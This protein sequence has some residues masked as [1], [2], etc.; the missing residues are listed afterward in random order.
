MGLEYTYL[1]SVGKAAAL[2]VAGNVAASVATGAGPIVAISPAK[3][4]A[5]VIL[6]AGAATAGTLPTLDAALFESDDQSTWTA[7]PNGA[8]TRVTTANSLQQIAIRPGERKTYLT[9]QLTIG[10]TVSP[11]FP[12]GMTVLY[13]PA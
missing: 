7:V 9:A 12:V 3:G 6:N 11:S 13:L 1:A 4:D 8:F 5:I 2:V 10:G